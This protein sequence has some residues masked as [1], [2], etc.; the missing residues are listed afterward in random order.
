ME[1]DRMGMSYYGHT[2][3][4]LALNNRAIAVHEQHEVVD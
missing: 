1:A 2:L 3:F 4:H